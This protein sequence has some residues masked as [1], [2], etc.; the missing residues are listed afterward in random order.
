MCSSDLML[1]TED[2]SVAKEIYHSPDFDSRVT[3]HPRFHEL[4]FGKNV[5]LFLSSGEPWKDAR[6]YT[7]KTLRQF[8]FGEVKTTE[9]FIDEELLHFI[10]RL[11]QDRIAGNDEICMRK[12]F[13][14]SLFNCIWKVMS[15]SRFEYSDP[16][17]NE[18]V[19]DV[20]SATKMEIGFDIE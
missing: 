6:R 19:E 18:I 1:L 14:V 13:K 16:K 2:H 8:G 20:E 7:I 17:I 3:S 5:G 15:G 9:A 10:E 4:T 12:Y 11:E